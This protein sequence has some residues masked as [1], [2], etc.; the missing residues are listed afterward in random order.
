MLEVHVKRYDCPLTSPIAADGTFF[1]R[2]AEES[3]MAMCL[4]SLQLKATPS[5]ITSKTRAEHL[6]TSRPLAYGLKGV[7]S[8]LCRFIC[9]H[10]F[11]LRDIEDSF[12][13]REFTC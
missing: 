13:S 12:H 11:L 4:W 5:L 6:E 3:L 10:G 7:D 2:Q 9:L 1:I 8:R